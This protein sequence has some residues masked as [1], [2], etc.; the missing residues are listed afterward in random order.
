MSQPPSF[1]R[2]PTQASNVVEASEVPEQSQ[3]KDTSAAP[4][5]EGP[6]AKAT[7]PETSKPHSSK[8]MNKL[9]PRF[10]SDVLEQRDQGKTGRT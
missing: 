2:D 3:A 7:A 5:F 8:I 10:D 6:G 1:Q 9:D 4:A